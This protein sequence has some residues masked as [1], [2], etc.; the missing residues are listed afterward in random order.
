M[1]L[2]RKLGSYG[3]W[4]MDEYISFRTNTTS[5]P[6]QIRDGKSGLVLSVTRVSAGLYTIALRTDRPSPVRHIVQHVS[7]NSAANTAATQAVSGA[8]YVDGSWSQTAGTFQVLVTDCNN[9][10]PAAVDPDS[11]A[12]ISITLTS[13]I[14]SVGTDAA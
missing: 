4:V 13:S 1:K 7:V 14:S 11:H 8:R 9:T 6:D 3:K 10:T 5:A 12:R 2:E